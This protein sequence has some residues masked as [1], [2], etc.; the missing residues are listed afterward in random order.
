MPHEWQKCKKKNFKPSKNYLYEY[1]YTIIDKLLFVRYARFGK[2][3]RTILMFKFNFTN[4]KADKVAIVLFISFVMWYYDFFN[5]PDLENFNLKE[6]LP[7]PQNEIVVR[8]RDIADAIK[9]QQKISAD[10]N[11]MYN[12]LKGWKKITW[13]SQPVDSASWFRKIH[14]SPPYLYAPSMRQ[15]QK[16]IKNYEK[17]LCKEA[18][19]LAKTKY[20]HYHGKQK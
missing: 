7:A 18:E 12:E 10:F 2:N 19:Q 17:D 1:A 20:A 4:G 16:F 3:K 9:H 14:P 13:P 15:Y 11:R 5:K 8:N 6:Q